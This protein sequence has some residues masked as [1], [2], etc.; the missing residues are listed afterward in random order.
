M[1]RLLSLFAAFGIIA[2]APATASV[3]RASPPPPSR[4]ISIP[5]D[6]PLGETLVYRVSRSDPRNPQRAPVAVEMQLRFTRDVDGFILTMVTPLPAGAPDDETTRLIARPFSVRL[7]PDG[8]L[9]G[10]VDDAGFWAALDNLAA[11][12]PDSA[13]RRATEAVYARMR[14][15]PPADLLAIIGSRFA[16]VIA[17]AGT[18][19]T[20]GEIAQPDSPTE[21]VIGRLTMHSR[22]ISE[23][24][25]DETARITII[26]GVPPEQLT[27]G[28][29][30][31]LHDLGPSGAAR[32]QVHFTSY[33]DRANYVVSRR[34]GLAENFTSTRTIT[35][36][37]D[38]VSE[39]VVQTRELH[40]VH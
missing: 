6:P 28:M 2:S 14:T 29:S 36:E 31:M 38:G 8:Q 19:V 25:D 7:S 18:N 10:I 12:N 4:A 39:S 22:V 21:T 16:P 17:F 37:Q 24:V 35:A 30:N 33:E 13:E 23:T 32:I 26:G 3:P 34:T 27:G 1:F 20:Q 40:R 11:R 5:F 15:L 9:I